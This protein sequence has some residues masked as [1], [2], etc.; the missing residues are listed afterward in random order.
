MGDVRG[1]VL[2]AKGNP[3]LIIT[4]HL[5][6]AGEGAQP[7]P[8]SLFCA[9]KVSAPSELVA[10]ECRTILLAPESSNWEEAMASAERRQWRTLWSAPACNDWQV[11]GAQQQARVVR[12]PPTNTV[13]PSGQPG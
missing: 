3:R 11:N 6:Q 9:S 12:G 2:G 5:S 1:K 10:G 8:G 7:G 13:I 4:L